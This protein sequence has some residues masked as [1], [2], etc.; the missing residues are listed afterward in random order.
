MIQNI[1]SIINLRWHLRINANVVNNYM[2]CLNKDGFIIF[3]YIKKTPCFLN[4]G[5]LLD[6]KFDFSTNKTELL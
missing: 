3:Y 1:N 2:N 4:T 5:I 6:L